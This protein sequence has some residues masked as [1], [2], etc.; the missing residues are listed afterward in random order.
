MNETRAIIPRSYHDTCGTSQSKPIRVFILA[1]DFDRVPSPM[2][3][4]SDHSA[5]DKIDADISLR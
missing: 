1:T 3:Q 2:L 4:R 5:Q